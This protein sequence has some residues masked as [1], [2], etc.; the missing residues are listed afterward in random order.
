MPTKAKYQKSDPVSPPV[1]QKEFDA[2]LKSLSKTQREILLMELS[3]LAV[4]QIADM[5][6]CRPN[7][8]Y[9]R[10]AEA[11]RRFGFAKK[12]GSYYNEYRQKIRKLFQQYASEELRQEIW[13]NLPE[14]PP[15]R[16]IYVTRINAEELIQQVTQQPGSLVRLRGPKHVG[17]TLLHLR[18]LD[19]LP[20]QD[21]RRV[22]LSFKWADSQTFED[23][24]VFLRWFCAVV[25]R[26]LGLANQ[27]KEV[28]DEFLSHSYNVTSYFETCILENVDTPL[29]LVL[30]D[31]DLVFEHKAIAQDFSDLLRVW[32][33]QANKGNRMSH[34]WQKLRLWIVHST[35]IYGALDINSSP[36]ANVGKVIAIGEFNAEQVEKLAL[37]MQVELTSEQITALMHLVGGHPAL[38]QVTFEHL[39]QGTA[40]EE[41]LDYA[42]TES[43]IYASYLR[44]QLE[45]L[46]KTP[47]L[48]QEFQH[49][50]ESP[51]PIQVNTNASF[52]LE[53]MGLT[54]LK[55]DLSAPR[56][57]LYRKYFRNRL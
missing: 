46:H 51:E 25:S 8:V 34:Q 43:S 14:P 48:A 11:Y 49:I 55:G 23:L 31:M 36:L 30:D 28:W 3:G 52:Q 32:N 13:G 20:M 2:C 24:G 35:E 53:S 47:E 33:G 54:L 41:I 37:Q 16:E 6:A 1:N 4:D 18:L 17:K 40:F 45:I 39:N 5:R 9:R 7:V 10:R 12:P 27:V 44:E 26:E 38:V 29:V 21:Y 42:H 57:Q 19:Q 50:I 56:N 15:T 22:A